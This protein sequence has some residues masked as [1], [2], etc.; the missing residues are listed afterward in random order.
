MASPPIM[1]RIEA[2]KQDRSRHATWINDI[3]RLNMPTYRRVDQSKDSEARTTEQDDLFDT[4]LQEQ[5]EDFAS[6]MIATFT[7]DYE[8]WVTFEPAEDLPPEALQYL[9][10]QL[11]AYGKAI[12]AEIDRSN[13][14][15]AAQECF[16]FWA[17]SAMACAVSD[18]GPLE[19]IHFQPIELADLLMERGAD[20]STTG[21]WREIKTSKA[22]LHQLWPNIFPPPTQKDMA[23]SKPVMVY[24]G[25]DRDYSVP[26]EEAWFYRIIVDG[27]EKYAK[28]F[29][30]PGSASIIACRFRQQADSAWGPGPAHKAAPRARVLDELSYLSLKALQKS[31][32]PIV[33]YEEDGVIN[34]EGGLEPGTWVPRAAGSGKPEAMAPET[35]FNALIFKQDELA[36]GIKKS[37]YQ[38][39]PEQPGDTPPTATQWLDEKAWNTRRRQLPRGRCAREWVLPIIERV[40]WILQQ[41]GTLQPIRLQ[42][43]KLINVKPVSPMSK[44]KDL[45]DIQVTAQVVSIVGQ[46]GALKAQGVPV[47]TLATTQNIINTAKERHI[48]MMTQEEIQAEQMAMAAQQQGAAGVA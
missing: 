21:R 14:Y 26:G 28:R 10:P 12:F 23:D 43:G 8:R 1:K 9:K 40:A 32:D 24:D 7:P 29:V 15:D 47:N 31:V 35:N 3:L 38:D 48:Q 2:A 33:S 5:T 17:V 34:I 42:G 45:E 20:G 27:K 13:Y 19:P 41:R 22:G 6:D 4:T 25:C 18:M 16:A 37:L 30:G 44:A 39:R 11:V 46:V 36:K